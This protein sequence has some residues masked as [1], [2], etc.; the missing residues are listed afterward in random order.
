MRTRASRKGSI[1]PGDMAALLSKE[2]ASLRD[3]TDCATH[4]RG[5]GEGLSAALSLDSRRHS[6]LGRADDYPILSYEDAGLP[7][8]LREH[9]TTGTAR[10][11]L[12]RLA[13]A[14]PK[15]LTDVQIGGFASWLCDSSAR[16]TGA[17]GLRAHIEKLA[18][19]RRKT[20]LEIAAILNAIGADFLIV[21]GAAIA[22]RHEWYA[23]RSMCDIDVLVLHCEN[24]LRFVESLGRFA[25]ITM[26]KAGIYGIRHSLSLGLST[27]SGLVPVDAE[28]NSP[29][30]R[31]GYN[32]EHMAL[33]WERRK[34]VDVNGC[35]LNLPSAEDSVILLAAHC[36]HHNHMKL[37]D[38]NDLYALALRDND[39]FDWSYMWGQA[40][41]V[42]CDAILDMLLEK[43][44][45]LYPSSAQALERARRARG[46]PTAG[47]R[48]IELCL[49]NGRRRRS[50]GTVA[51]LLYSLGA[52]RGLERGAMWRFLLWEEARAQAR[53]IHPRIAEIAG[54]WAWRLDVAL[55]R[56][57]RLP[58]VRLAHTRALAQWTDTVGRL[59]AAPDRRIAS[60]GHI[61]VGEW[62]FFH[63]G[64]AGVVVVSPVGV[65]GSRVERLA[66]S[67]PARSETLWP[68]SKKRRHPRT[69]ARAA[70]WV[71]DDC[72][73]AMNDELSG[74]RESSH[75]PAAAGA[76]TRGFVV[77]MKRYKEAANAIWGRSDPASSV[78]MVEIEASTFCDAD[79]I[80][81]PRDRVLRPRANMT[82]GVMHATVRWLAQWKEAPCAFFS[83][84]GEPLFNPDLHHFVAEIKRD[85]GCYVGLNTNAAHM[86]P[87]RAAELVDSGVDFFHISVPSSD[88]SIYSHIMPSLS[89]ADVV[90][91]TQHLIHVARRRSVVVIVVVQ[92]LLNLGEFDSHA[93]RWKRAG[94]AAVIPIDCHNRGG[95]L[96]L[97]GLAKP[98]TIV[99][100][101]NCRVFDRM[102]VVDVEGHLLPCVNDI[103]NANVF[104]M[105]T[106]MSPTQFLERKRSDR[107]RGAGFTM[108]GSCDFLSDSGSRG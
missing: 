54:A 106:N 8:E 39:A 55:G 44:Q 21:K 50:L 52:A 4:L 22:M 19:A 76:S 20:T 66:A 9:G 15:A 49:T 16:S 2:D 74:S 80:F 73:G 18:D 86:T 84:M 81:C 101:G 95:Q 59:V 63:S 33:I 105:V 103:T 62:H 47:R 102:H 13:D 83:G 78:H 96:P 27:K 35:R 12:L 67:V 91:N 107:I 77:T 69:P 97:A 40:T 29:F 88:A 42:R 3:V 5:L 98:G 6:G 1:W 46:V 90:T 85:T 108:C 48:A 82:P 28:L 30:V 65:F 45:S 25:A 57:I 100:F 24:T 23:H 11:N 14:Y 93:Q 36:L 10:R 37:R 72:E 60:Y 99:G 38:V 79:C 58:L 87:E 7:G 43:A 61:R 94:A 32:K 71:E 92:T 64:A 34:A 51:G 70:Q 53:K 26:M 41:Q 31:S 89:F 68:C 17:G 104:G 75:I 56:D